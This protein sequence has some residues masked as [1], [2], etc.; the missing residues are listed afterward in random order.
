MTLSIFAVGN[1]DFGKKNIF[2]NV[3]VE[4]NKIKRDG[5][6]RSSNQAP[7]NKVLVEALMGYP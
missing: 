7:S 4:A 2:L 3:G 6:E 1:V 5:E